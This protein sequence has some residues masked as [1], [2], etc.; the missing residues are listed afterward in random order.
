[1]RILGMLF[2][3]LLI[4]GAVAIWRGWCTVSAANPGDGSAVGIEVDRGR[5]NDDT[6]AAMRR[7]GELSER[8]VDTVK[9]IAR[10]TT[11]DERVV[12]G[13]VAVVDATARDLIV[14]SGARR[15]D[16]IVPGSVAIRRDGRAVPL[17]QLA[18]GHRVSLTFHVDGESWRLQRV[19]L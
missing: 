2:G 14:T 16:V 7:I 1:M 6:H 13:S 8:V 5:I 3:V 9:S 10:A 17:G 12:E 4:V 15:I 19:E 11:G 18:A